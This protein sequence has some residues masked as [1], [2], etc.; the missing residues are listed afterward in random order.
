MEVYASSGLEHSVKLH[1]AG[2]HHYQVGGHG[3]GADEL[4]QG[5]NHLLHL[6][7]RGRILDDV[8]LVG[9]LRLLSPLPGVGEGLD[10]GGGILARFLAEEDV[11]G[12]VGV[13][14]RVQVDQVDGL[15]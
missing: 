10:L 2:G 4:A 11:V 6:Q 3:V 12:G 9:P 13:E 14:G 8:Q 7:G 1:Q 5:R 15:V